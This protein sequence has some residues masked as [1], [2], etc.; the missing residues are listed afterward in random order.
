VLGEWGPRVPFWAAAALAGIA[1]LYGLAVLPESLP[2]DKRMA[3]S[4]RRANPFGALALLRSH[5]ELTG[6]SVV[7]F[8]LFFAHHIFSAVFVLYAAHRYG[9]STA[10]IGTSLALWGVLDVLIQGVAVG[11]VV[12][13]F[14]DRKTM[15]FGLIMGAIG[16]AV[17]GMAPDGLTFVLGIFVSALWG[18]AMP[19]LQS[20]MTRL[21]SESEQ[22]QLQGANMSVSSIAGIASPLFFGWVYSIS[23]G[24]AAVVKAPGLS[25]LLAA[26]ILLAAGLMGLAVSRRAVR[27]S[28]P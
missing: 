14:G 17:L 6:L 1:F 10:E 25:F 13:R 23:V 27:R 15:E 18:F 16:L 19:T 21:V 8:L 24:P 12:K 22:G 4:W 5:P 28:V 11:P 3:F 9:W 2:R 20:L 7:N 26:A